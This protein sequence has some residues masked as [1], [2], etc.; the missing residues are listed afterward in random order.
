M[1]R[2]IL[3]T[4]FFISV[5]TSQA[6]TMKSHT[7]ARGETIESIAKKYGITLEELLKANPGAEKMHYVGMVL[8]IPSQTIS[9][10]RKSSEIQHVQTPNK[11][12]IQ[13]E[14]RNTKKKEDYPNE[15]KY[16]VGLYAGASLNNN[17]G[18]DIEG[19]NIKMGFHAGATARYF[20]SRH[21]FG[22]ISVGYATKGY[23]QEGAQTSGPYWNDDGSNYDSEN[24]NTMQTSNIDIPI[25]LGYRINISEN[26]AIDLKIG[27]YMT[28]ALDGK[29]KSRGTFTFYPDIHSSETESISSDRKIKDMHYNRFGAGL[30]VGLGMKVKEH[31]YVAG[32]YQQGFTKLME[33]TK[34]YERNILISLGIIL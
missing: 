14:E 19:S 25:H 27:P 9:P 7:I 29:L 10:E 34:L 30:D 32:G 20:I 26:L 6:Q 1:K 12:H 28:Y 13:I 18:D 8:N 11:T 5:F 2:I 17:Y 23:K 31:F 22:D 33:N 21:F 3:F 4:L 16:E 24:K 15:K